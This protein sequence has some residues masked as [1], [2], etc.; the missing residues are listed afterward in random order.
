MYRY[1]SMDI[2]FA[3]EDSNRRQI[4]EMLA[5]RGQL[6]AS[7][8]SKMFY[9]SPPAIS[10]HLKVL[11]EADLVKVEKKEQKRLYSINPEKMLELETWAKKLQTV[12]FTKI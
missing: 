6:S 3:L 5:T 1:N 10:Q 2:F 7:Q 8:I 12:K 9:V 11:R 4:I